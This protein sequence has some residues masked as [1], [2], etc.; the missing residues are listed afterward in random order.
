MNAPIQTSAGFAEAPIVSIETRVISKA[1]DR[2]QWNPRTRWTHKHV[3]LAFVRTEAGVLGVGEAYCDGGATDSVCALIER[4]MAPLAVGRK[5]ADLGAIA[6]AMR[7][8]MVVSAKGGAAWAALSAVDIA[9]WDALGRSLGVP[10]CTLLGAQRRRV[11]A[12]ASAGL[13]GQGKGLDALAAEMRGYVDQGFR[14]VKIKV[15]GASVTEDL[16][17]VAAVREAIGVGS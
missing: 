5:L 2:A 16:A 7:D 4:D 9:L 6:A 15:G 12:Y 14:G 1:F 3:V 8:S 13:Y 11:Y 17:R 10:V